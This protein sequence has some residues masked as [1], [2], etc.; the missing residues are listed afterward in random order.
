MTNSV[1]VDAARHNGNMAMPSESARP[2]Y[3]GDLEPKL[4]KKG[5]RGDHFKKCNVSYTG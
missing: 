1:T 5:S 2:Q 3:R 4:V